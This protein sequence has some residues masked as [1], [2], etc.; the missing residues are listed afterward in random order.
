MRV[1]VQVGLRMIGRFCKNP[2]DNTVSSRG[3]AGRP[4]CF[5][6]FGAFGTGG[7]ELSGSGSG[8]GFGSCFG[9]DFGF[10]RSMSL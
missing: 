8:S 6:P 4:V 9:P 7:Y 5:L 10:V 2:W 1:W 3:G